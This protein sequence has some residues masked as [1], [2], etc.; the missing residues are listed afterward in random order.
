MHCDG[1]I[2]HPSKRAAKQFRRQ[3]PRTAKQRIYRC[4]E[5]GYWHLTNK[6]YSE[7]PKLGREWR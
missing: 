3:R 4:P 7:Q 5:C 2:K 1:K 6:R